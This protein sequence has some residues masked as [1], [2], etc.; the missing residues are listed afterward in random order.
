MKIADDKIAIRI[1]PKKK[2]VRGIYIPEAHKTIGLVEGV[3]EVVG[4]GR[5]YPD[6]QRRP[7]NVQVGDRVVINNIAALHLTYGK[8]GEEREYWICKEGEIVVILEDGETVDEYLEK[9]ESKEAN[10][11]ST[12]GLF[13]GY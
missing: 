3:V 7:P 6:G 13:G 8:D 5:Y 11:T 12:A 4:P 1:P 9:N 10:G 2:E